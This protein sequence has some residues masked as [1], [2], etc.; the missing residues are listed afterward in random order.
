M[1]PLTPRREFFWRVYQLRVYA[2][3]GW[4][5]CAEDGVA[6]LGDVA[7]RLGLDYCRAVREMASALKRG[8]KRRFAKL[9]ELWY[10]QL[11]WSDED[12]AAMFMRDRR[13]AWRSY[14]E[15]EGGKR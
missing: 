3:G 14:V 7:I 5:R 2:Q 1:E 11:G 13:D 9:A 6:K 10:R 15:S 8:D 12:L 4:W